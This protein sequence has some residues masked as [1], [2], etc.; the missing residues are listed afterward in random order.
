MEEK[1]IEKGPTDWGER[2][3]DNVNLMEEGVSLGGIERGRQ[4][5]GTFVTKNG[6]AGESVEK[7]LGG[8]EVKR[9]GA[10]RLNLKYRN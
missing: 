9:W 6:E 2:R 10:N 4:P 8:E 1:R 3:E 7:T 5:K